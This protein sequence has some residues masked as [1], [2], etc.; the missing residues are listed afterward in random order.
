[1]VRV[2]ND[3]T[4]T[5]DFSVRG[6]GASPNF[7]VKWF[8]GA[9]NITSQVRAGSYR[10]EDLVARATVDLRVEIKIENTAPDNARVN[11]KTTI[12][13]ATSPN[14]RD[15]VGTNVSR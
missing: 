3:G 10:V 12:R 11:V 8:R 5:D 14:Y 1:V 9:T 2:Q 6:A 7:E 4:V 15:V 13:A